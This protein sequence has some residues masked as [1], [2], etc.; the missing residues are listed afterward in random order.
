MATANGA[1]VLAPTRHRLFAFARRT[2]LLRHMIWVNLRLVRSTKRDAGVHEKY[3]IIAK[4]RRVSQH[5][6]TRK[7]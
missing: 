7:V 1:K 6:K 4:S 3:L 5:R 2:K